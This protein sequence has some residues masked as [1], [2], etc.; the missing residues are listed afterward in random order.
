M[1]K[2]ASTTNRVSSAKVI[3]AAMLLCL[4][5][6]RA[7]T[8]AEEASIE[9]WSSHDQ[10]DRKLKPKNKDMDKGKGSTKG[11]T[12]SPTS[13]PTLAPNVSR[14][15]TSRPTAVPTKAPSGKG[16]ATTKK[17][18][19]GKKGNGKGLTKAPT[20]SPTA[21]PTASPTVL[22]VQDVAGVCPRVPGV[23]EVGCAF[24]S[25]NGGNPNDLVI[26]FDAEQFGVT[27][28]LKLQAVRFWLG[29]S[30]DLPA[31]L[32]LV[33]WVGSV[34]GGPTNVLYTQSL[35]P[36]SYMTGENTVTLSPSLDVLEAEFCVG[37]SSD[38][39]VDG[40]RV[41]VSP[42]TDATSSFFRAP[43]CGDPNF[44]SLVSLE[45]QD[46]D[47]PNGGYCIEAIVTF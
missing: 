10:E 27:V 37:L 8:G 18:P 16:E 19:S 14:R 24:E 26:C 45:S 11:P 35:T 7:P 41:G 1:K 15:P 28:P 21:S 43:N 30:T 22:T 23:D 29:V 46:P 4:M 25:N 12:A 40:L 31:D 13:L 36:S 32:R 17:A 2:V 9:I 3:L 33:V 5:V 20:P 44:V 42:G 34:S 6:G 47:F 39:V 38:S